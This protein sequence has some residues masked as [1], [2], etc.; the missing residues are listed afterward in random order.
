MVL[1]ARTHRPVAST[2][3]ETHRVLGPVLWFASPTEGRTTS[4]LQRFAVWAWRP[5]VIAFCVVGWVFLSHE[6]APSFVLQI[7]VARLIMFLVGRLYARDREWLIKSSRI[8]PWGPKGGG[9]G[10]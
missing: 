4:P 9:P 3:R 5:F 6:L 8:W 1:V 2:F 7:L 10:P